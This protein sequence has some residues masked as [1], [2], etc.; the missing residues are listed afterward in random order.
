MKPF[1][2][3][4]R[5]EKKELLDGVW[6]VRR[7]CTSSQRGN[8]SAHEAMTPKADLEMPVEEADLRAPPLAIILLL[9]L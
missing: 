7:R 6:G 2:K 8:F 1:V 9:P 4:P 5:G 3:M